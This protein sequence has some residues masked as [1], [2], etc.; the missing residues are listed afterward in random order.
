[1]LTNDLK[2]TI[3]PGMRTLNLIWFA[4]T[5]AVVIYAVLGWIVGGSIEVDTETAPTVMFWPLGAGVLISVLL[6][7]V[8][9]PRFLSPE[10]LLR[11]GQV[12]A[13]GPVVEQTAAYARLGEGDR[14]RADH[15]AAIQT[16]FII[17]WA[18]IES[19]AIYPLMALFMG[20]ASVYSV[21]PVQAVVLALLLNARP[22][23]E[24]E[25]ERIKG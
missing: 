6:G 19:L 24:A 12:S 9:V 8:I 7:W 5:F 25:I 11:R 18:A 14:R 16:H 10:Q 17:R 3:A 15:F 1:M 20:I 21:W 4:F 13:T 2:E 22:D 23:V